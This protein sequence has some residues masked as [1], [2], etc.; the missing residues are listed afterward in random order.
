MLARYGI[1]TD[2]AGASQAIELAVSGLRTLSD[3][4]R[5]LNFLNDLP[6]VSTVTLRRARADAVV[7]QLHTT[8]SREQLRQSIALGR[9]LM[10]ADEPAAENLLG[11]VAPMAYRLN[12]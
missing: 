8:A 4:G 7:Y 12:R 1:G 11:P 6:P 3:Y 9:V 5:V 2:Q 10:P